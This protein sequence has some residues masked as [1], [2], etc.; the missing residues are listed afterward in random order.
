MNVSCETYDNVVVVSVDGELSADT[1][2]IFKSTV[3][4]ELGDGHVRFVVNF[5]KI[6]LIDS[7]GLEALWWLKDQCQEQNGDLKLACLD[8][9]SKTIL[10]M[11]RLD[12]LFDSY[13]QVIKAV[14]SFN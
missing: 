7:E 5:E 9:T 12:R 6:N 3:S 8:D 4:E 1:L 14:T 13:E 11:T 10:T 2:E